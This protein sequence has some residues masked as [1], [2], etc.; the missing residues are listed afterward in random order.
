MKV[1]VLGYHQKR[2]DEVQPPKRPFDPIEDVD[3][4]FCKEPGW[5]IPFRELAESELRILQGMRVHVGLHHCELS[6][7]E[8]PDGRFSIACQSHPALGD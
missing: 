6:V 5:L 1:Y 2:D 8:F 3:V 7:E 4:R